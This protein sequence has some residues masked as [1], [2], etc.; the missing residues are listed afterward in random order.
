MFHESIKLV[1][2]VKATTKAN[3]FEKA[4]ALVFRD[5]LSRSDGFVVGVV[6]GFVVGLEVVSGSGSFSD[7]LHKS[8]LQSIQSRA[9]AILLMICFITESISSQVW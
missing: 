9:D 1:V 4:L 5:E 3:V 6:V 7:P 2:P 8:V